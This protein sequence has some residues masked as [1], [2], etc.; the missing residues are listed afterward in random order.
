MRSKATN[1]PAQ[2]GVGGSEAAPDPQ[3]EALHNEVHARPPEALTAPLAISH[4]VMVCDALEREASRAHVQRLL[5]D[6]HLPQPDAACTHLRMEVGRFRIRWELHT[7]FVSWTFL[8][9]A[10][11]EAFGDREP[12]CAA[13]ATTNT[14]LGSVGGWLANR[15]SIKA[16]V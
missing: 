5:R 12:E 9:P 8:Y 14:N 7:E 13:V 4:V 1:P 16:I 2:G 10:R 15:C 3:R 6:H 11:L